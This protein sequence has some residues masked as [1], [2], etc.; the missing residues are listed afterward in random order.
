MTRNTNRHNVK[1][2]LFGI[3]SM[4]MIL[5]RRASALIALASLCWRKITML[6]GIVHRVARVVL[7]RVI[8][9]HSLCVCFCQLRKVLRMGDSPVLYIGSTSFSIGASPVYRV[10]SAFFRVRPVANYVVGFLALLTSW[11][12]SAGLAFV[13]MKLIKPFELLTFSASLFHLCSKK[14]SCHLVFPDLSQPGDLYKEAGIDLETKKSPRGCDFN[15][16]P[17]LVMVAV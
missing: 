7:I 17:Q 4:V 6:Y 14:N 12:Q 8:D 10:G 2:M 5:A 1:P 9:A 13:H 15:I 16:L 11:I 3:T